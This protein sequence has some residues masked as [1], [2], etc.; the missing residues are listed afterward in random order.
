MAQRANRKLSLVFNLIAVLGLAGAAAPAKAQSDYPSRPVRILV[1]VTAGASGDISARTL[2]QKLSQILNQQFIV[3]NRPGAGTS[4]AADLVAKAPKDGYTLFLGS[5]ANTINATLS[6]DLAFDFGKDFA[7]IMLYANVPNVLVVNPSLN[8]SSVNDLIARAKAK[9]DEVM[10]GSSGS[11][12][13]PHLSG[14]LFN[15]MAGTKMTHVPYQGSSQ[16]MPDL[17]SGRINVMFAPASTVAPFIQSGQ[18]KALA[19]STLRRSALTPD[20][21]TISESGLNGFDTSVWMGILAPAGTPKPIID[22]LADAITQATK[23]D[24]F[25]QPLQKQGFDVMAIGPDD[26]G[27][28]IA[29]ETAKWAGVLQRAGLVKK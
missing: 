15:V 4:L 11:G 16:A 22:K 17:V 21:P 5:I 12:T 28:Y 9:P 25:V 1:G 24:D 6:S 10:F 13:A 7:P 14:E 23:A 26:F 8:A 19:V 29:S 2:A 27:K 20:L 3:E 18:L